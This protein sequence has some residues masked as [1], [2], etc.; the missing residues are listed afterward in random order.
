MQ[1]GYTVTAVSGNNLMKDI[2]ERWDC[3]W[4][5]IPNHFCV[6]LDKTSSSEAKLLGFNWKISE[7]I[8]IKVRGYYLI[9]EMPIVYM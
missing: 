4:E 3:Q 8:T 6:I 1:S 9:K 5:V 2:N 7:K